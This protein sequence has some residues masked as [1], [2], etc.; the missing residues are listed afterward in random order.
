MTVDRAVELSE[1]QKK[2]MTEFKRE[3]KATF[4]DGQVT[5][6]NEA[7]L[8]TKL[9]QISCGAVYGEQHA[10][11][12]VDA[13]PRLAV[14]R[15]VIGECREKILIFAP[16]TSVVSLLYTE[17]SRDYT[18]EVINGAVSAGKRSEVFRDFQ[19]AE[20]P[21]IIVADPRTMA[22]GL[23][24]TAASTIIWYGP[25]DQPEIYTQ[26]NGR[27]NRPGQTKS[28]LVVRLASTNIEREIYKRLDN[29]QGLQG[30]ML[31][32]IRGED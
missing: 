29:K 18:V 24:L 17:L 9:I 22:H 23:T 4:K 13:A 7:A 2:A 20:N 14:L 30:L 27:I 28:M 8:R 1:A 21:R 11:H 10:V 25:T 31:D 26:A 6:V 12:K 32:I 3:L 19:S 15:E 5:A 16:L